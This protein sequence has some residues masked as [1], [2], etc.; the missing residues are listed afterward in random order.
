MPHQHKQMLTKLMQHQARLHQQEL[1]VWHKK[2]DKQ[3]VVHLE[4]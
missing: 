3:L 2:P 1:R 4:K